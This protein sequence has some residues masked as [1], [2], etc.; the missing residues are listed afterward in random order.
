MLKLNKLSI[1]FSDLAAAAVL[2][3]EAPERAVFTV[4]RTLHTRRHGHAA[5]FHAGGY[6]QYSLFC[7][8]IW[9]IF[10]SYLRT[11]SS[12]REEIKVACHRIVLIA[13]AC[14]FFSDGRF[15]N[16][17]KSKIYSG[18]TLDPNIFSHYGS[19]EKFLLSHA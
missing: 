7:E 1:M 18:F 2:V 10:Y 3:H 15:I 4:T 5:S 12:N 17:A 16:S 19:K 8:F 13:C 6:K 14:V 11:F 9:L